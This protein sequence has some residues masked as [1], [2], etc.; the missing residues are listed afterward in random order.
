[1]AAPIQPSQTPIPTPSDVADVARA[2]DPAARNRAVTRGYHLFSQRLREH[3]GDEVSWPTLAAWASA[4][5]GHTIRKEDLLRVLE[6]RLGDGPAIRRIIDGPFRDAARL[7]LREVL[8]LDPFE[9]SS[10]AVSRGNIKVY[11]EIGAEFARFLALL[12]ASPSPRQLQAFCDSLR[13]GP[14]PDG[15]DL[16][17][18]AFAAYIEAGQTPAGTGRSQLLFLANASIGVH[19]QTRLQPEIVAAVDG[20][21]IDGME[22]KARLTATLLPSLRPSMSGLTARLMESQL[23]PLLAPLIGEVQRLVREIV[24]ERMMVL[25]LPGG[26]L[27]LGQDLSG[28][29]PPDLRVLTNATAIALLAAVDLTPDSMRGSGARNWTSF[30]ERMHFIADL[31]RSR[32]SDVRLFEHP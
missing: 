28:T 26:P 21:V 7:I 22:I 19:E 25:E 3:L 17:K 13:P 27:R 15:Q 6:R 18:Q 1:M 8:R 31:F 16:L 30:P 4:Q 12:A 20:S 32:Q 2:T 14:P 29:F 9:R 11:A 5:A 10:R 23:E 24:T